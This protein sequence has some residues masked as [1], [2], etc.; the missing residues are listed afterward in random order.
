MST[1]TETVDAITLTDA[2]AEASNKIQDWYAEPGRQVFRLFGYA[3][4]G[5]STTADTIVRRLGVHRPV[6]ATFTGKAAHVLRTKGVDDARTIHSLIYIP[7]EKLRQKLNALIEQLE[8]VTDPEERKILTRRIAAEQRRLDSPDWLLREQDESDLAQADLLVVDEVSMVGERMAMDLLS[9]GTKTL[10]LGDPGQLPPIEGAGYFVDATPDHLLTE[11][12]RTAL[13]SPVTRIAT[14]IRSAQPGEPDYGMRF[15]DG[16]GPV[17]NITVGEL[18]DIDQILVGTNKTRWQAIHL[19]RALRGLTSTMP[20]PGDRVMAL[21]NSSA[22]EVFNGQQ[23]DVAAVHDV[24]DRPDRIALDVVDDSGTTR[25]LVAWRAGF[26]G[27]EG[28]QA[29]KRDGR[30]SVAAMTFAQAVTVH[31]AQGSQWDRVLVVDESA[32]FARMEETYA[33]KTGKPNPAALGYRAGQR[34]L[35][36][37]VTRAAKQVIILPRLTGAIRGQR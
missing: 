13:D 26:T 35:Y 37:A 2:Q 24:T 12:L 25:Q 18:L 31:K 4:T 16:N 30:G 22:A 27:L 14:K 28:E 34:H 23:F 5:K 11:V 7:S 29:A 10:V 21:A 17:E 9:W 32:V 3:G 19:V 15:D 8:T 36:T 20:Q 6:Y 33:R 1:A